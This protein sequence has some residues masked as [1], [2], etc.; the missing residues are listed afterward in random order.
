VTARQNDL[1]LILLL[2]LQ[3]LIAGVVLTDPGVLGLNRT[4]V[5]WLVILN[6]VLTLVGNQ[7]K[8]I[9][10]SGPGRSPLQQPPGAVTA[11]GPQPVAPRTVA[12]LPAADTKEG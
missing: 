7:L 6:P 2:E 3:A 12:L 9:G 11:D 5:S 4:I 1:L 10:A 8:A